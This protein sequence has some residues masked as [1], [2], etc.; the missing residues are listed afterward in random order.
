[1][2]Q[3]IRKRSTAPAAPVETIEVQDRMDWVELLEVAD[4]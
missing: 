3:S 4:Y 2:G 1:M